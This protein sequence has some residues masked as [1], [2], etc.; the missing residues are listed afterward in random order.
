MSAPLYFF[1]RKSLGDVV[2]DDRYLPS[3]LREAGLEETFADVRSVGQTAINELTGHGPG[4][5][6]GVLATILP[7]SGEVPKRIG[8][9][10]DFQD[11][12]QAGPD[13]WIGTDREQPPT[14][15]DLVRSSGRRVPGELHVRPPHAGYELELADGQRWT[16]P[17]VRRPAIVAQFGAPLTSLPMDVGWDSEGKFVETI[18]PQYEAIWEDTA[19]ICDLFF[20]AEGRMRRGEFEI[21]VETGL[22]WCLRLLALNYR[23][24]RHEQNLLHAI[25]KE[26]AFIVLGLA[27]D[28]PLVKELLGARA[29]KKSPPTPAVVSM[30]PGSTAGSPITDQAGASSS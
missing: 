16:V 21:D 27:V 8:Y 26:N 23:Y 4:G 12:R 17:I 9:A 15:D 1:G 19:A 20:D 28:T 2:R 29:E 13:L 6:S 7:A 30:S 22:K 18:K 5:A 3:L 11:W 25:D 24:S 10:P 14:P